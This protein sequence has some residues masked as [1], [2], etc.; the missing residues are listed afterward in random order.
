[1]R[2]LISKNVICGSRRKDSSKNTHVCLVISLMSGK[3]KGA[4]SKLHNH[5]NAFVC[6]HLRLV[7]GPAK[8]PR[9]LAELIEKTQCVQRAVHL[10][11][12]ATNLR[13]ERIALWRCSPLSS[14]LRGVCMASW[15][16][17]QAF[18]WWLRWI[19]SSDLCG[20][21][22]VTFFNIGIFTSWTGPF[23]EGCIFLLLQCALLWSSMKFS[24]EKPISLCSIR[25]SSSSEALTKMQFNGSGWK[26]KLIRLI[27]PVWSISRLEFL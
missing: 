6:S 11:I 13:T 26:E 18:R 15:T 25:F 17:L 1:M 27:I 23:S 21:G 9:L 19:Q 20:F 8:S 4:Q 12:I 22:I 14:A 5:V 7:S 24:L 3:K 10:S 16:K 2:R